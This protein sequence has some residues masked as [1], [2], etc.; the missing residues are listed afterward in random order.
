MLRSNFNSAL[1]HLLANP[2]LR[3]EFSADRIALA[4]RFDLSEDDMG[5]WNTLDLQALEAQSQT[6][7][8]KRVHEARQLLPAT[9][10]GLGHEA[11]R[12]FEKFASEY[13]P[14]GHR[15]H[16]EDALEFCRFLKKMGRVE[17]CEIERIFLEGRLSKKRVSIFWTRNL[18]APKGP[19]SA[20]VVFWRKPKQMPRA[21]AFRLGVS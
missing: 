10:A 11:S 7:I 5:A 14:Q 16:L 20:L 13:W 15:R 21:F 9:F 4:K 2:G 6:L 19:R 12:L 17:L 8:H 1:G 18:P 3:E